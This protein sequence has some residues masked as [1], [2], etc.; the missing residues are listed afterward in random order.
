MEL[1]TMTCRNCGGK[2]SIS[3]ESDQCIC[4]HC[5]TEYLVTFNDGTISI[6]LLV[7]NLQ[8]I[9]ASSKNVAVE[10]ALERLRNEINE[11]WKSAWVIYEKIQY[12]NN[13][14][15]EYPSDYKSSDLYSQR[16]SFT[17]NPRGLEII[18]KLTLEKERKKFFSNE[19]KITLLEQSLR[20]CSLLVERLNKIDEEQN[21]Y[22]QVLNQS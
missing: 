6:K 12:S 3:K 2:L 11:S 16:G 5:G 7:E 4:L 18:L 17:F 15:F 20:K 14:N 21:T 13:I 9:Q 1:F 8:N 22:L 10:M 19:E